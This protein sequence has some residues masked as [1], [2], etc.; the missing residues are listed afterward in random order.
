MNKKSILNFSTFMFI[1]SILFLLYGCP[2]SS[3]VPL[4]ISTESIID[5][6][7][8]GK[9]KID[10]MENFGD[11][12][13]NDPPTITIIE[14]NEHE[15]LI[16]AIESG[17]NDLEGFRG[18]TTI[19]GDERFLNI[20]KITS[21]FEKR[22]WLFLNYNIVDDRFEYKIIGDKIFNEK[23]VS[24]EDLY[25]FLENNLENKNLYDTGKQILKRVVE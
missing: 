6:E 16:W 23:I 15:L 13:E 21:S 19:V 14:F 12:E 24:S 2:Y 7:L 4:S 10:H 22:K 9:W 25:T 3:D 20:Q 17:K 5:K 8:I 11:E 18:F 1:V